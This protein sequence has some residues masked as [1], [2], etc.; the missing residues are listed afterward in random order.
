MVEKSVAC[1]NCGHVG[2]LDA[3]GSCLD[4]VLC[5]HRWNL[6]NRKAMGEAAF[7]WLEES[8]NDQLEARQVA[9]SLSV[10]FR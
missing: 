9:R 5:A 6:N 2:P 1:R 3:H 4:S 7:M 8:V 10:H